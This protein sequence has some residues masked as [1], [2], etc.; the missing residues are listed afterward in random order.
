MDDDGG[1]VLPKASVPKR[2][3]SVRCECERTESC[4]NRLNTVNDGAKKSA[5]ATDESTDRKDQAK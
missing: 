3:E 2:I 1:I 5:V 4:L